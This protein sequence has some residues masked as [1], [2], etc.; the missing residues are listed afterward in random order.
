MNFLHFLFLCLISCFGFVSADVSNKVMSAVK[1]SDCLQQFDY[2]GEL[3]AS[4]NE[5]DCATGGS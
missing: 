3:S 2:H 1:A 4:N 5:N